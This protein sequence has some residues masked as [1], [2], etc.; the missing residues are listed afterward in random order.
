MAE[1]KAI[2]RALEAVGSEIE[3]LRPKARLGTPEEARL[4]QAYL[5]R[6]KL[7]KRQFQALRRKIAGMKK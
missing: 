3:S 5:R 7:Q 1:A 4:Q 2:D 6:E